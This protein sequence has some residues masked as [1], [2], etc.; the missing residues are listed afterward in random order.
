MTPDREQILETMI[1]LNSRCV[2]SL[3]AAYC[4]EFRYPV[5][6]TASIKRHEKNIRD[7]RLEIERGRNET[8]T[9]P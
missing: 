7:L 2:Q 4:H 3:A 6:V 1:F 5:W 9:Q 8:P